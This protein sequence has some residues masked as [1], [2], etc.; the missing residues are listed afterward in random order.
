MHVPHFIVPTIKGFM[1]KS[2]KKFENELRKSLTRLCENELEQLEGFE[3][4][5]HTVSF[6]NIQTS[7]K[8]ICVF[9]TND[10]LN[11]FLC[12]DDKRKIE[13][14][15]LKVMSELNVKLKN[16]S[17]QIVYDTEENCT[18][19]NKGNWAKRLA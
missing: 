5:T 7:L 9:D 17:K 16:T 1:R 3:W 8:I 18:R 12:S 4:L 11:H 10:S 15:I 13:T 14:R 2:D 19:M 6:P